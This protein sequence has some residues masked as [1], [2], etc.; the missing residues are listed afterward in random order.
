M[1]ISIAMASYNGEK[2]IKEQLES[3]V[4]QTR[5]PDELV[6]TDD[7]STDSTE[8]IVKRFSLLA[9]FPVIFHRNETNLGFV[10]NF[11]KAMSLCQGD[12]ICLSDQDDVWDKSKLSVVEQCFSE[13][14]Q[15][16]LFINDQLVCDGDLVSY[17]FTS[18]E[19]ARS[20]GLG[21]DW[22]I[23]G[24]CTSVR[25]RFFELVSPFPDDFPGHD[26]WLNKLAIYMGGRE[27]VEQPLQKYRRHDDNAS[28]TVVSDSGGGGFFHALR[29]YGTSDSRDQWNIEIGYLKLYR[30]RLIE[31]A[32]L[33]DINTDLGVVNGS[34][35]HI[36]KRAELLGK[37][38][39]LVGRNRFLR[40]LHVSL[41]WLQGGYRYSQGWKSAAKDMI[42]P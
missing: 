15:T 20:L 26:T 39:K 22:V 21:D 23:Y 17:G 12:I 13:S 5:L 2:F 6:I 34:V 30:E 25:K 27:I 19:K 18:F 29:K 42:R 11:E 7:G 38:I 24:C 32:K 35:W 36:E 9:P 4:S 10:K 3:F 28:A 37:R 33:G 16:Q 1:K 8:E 40:F 14:P 41:F 31:V